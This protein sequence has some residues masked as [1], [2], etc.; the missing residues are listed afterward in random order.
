MQVSLNDVEKPEI[1]R[2]EEIKELV[3]VLEKAN[4]E[5]NIEDRDQVREIRQMSKDIIDLFSDI[6]T[7]YKLLQ[8]RLFNIDR[9]K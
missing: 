5:L 8:D 7:Y 9:R 3:E 2:I 1:E 6:E 4:E